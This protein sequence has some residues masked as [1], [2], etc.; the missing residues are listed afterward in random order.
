MKTKQF[1]ECVLK[2]RLPFLLDE[3]FQVLGK[4]LILEHCLHNVLIKEGPRMRRPFSS[5]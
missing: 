2:G 4:T 1:F 3:L 5:D